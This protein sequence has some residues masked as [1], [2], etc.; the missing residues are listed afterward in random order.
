MGP[1]ILVRSLHESS[2]RLW[3]EDGYASRPSCQAPA[4][5]RGALEG[6]TAA[7]KQTDAGLLLRSVQVVT[8]GVAVAFPSLPDEESLVPVASGLEKRR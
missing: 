4:E 8:A 6:R 7:G 2:L 3:T 5:C 1:P